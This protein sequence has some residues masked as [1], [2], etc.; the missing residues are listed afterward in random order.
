MAQRLLGV[1]RG[2]NVVGVPARILLNGRL[3]W[4]HGKPM[5]R[6]FRKLREGRRPRGRRKLRVRR[7]GGVVGVPARILVTG[8][9]LR[10]YE[11]R[12]P[13]GFRRLREG[14]R[15]RGRRTMGV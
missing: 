5:P 15:P 6:G 2:G 11:K 12:I 13:R 14:T 10:T 3:L 9:L 8:G 7:G 4:N 1:R